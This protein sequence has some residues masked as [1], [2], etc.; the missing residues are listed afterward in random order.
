[1]NPAPILAT[2]QPTDE[3]DHLGVIEVTGPDAASFL[4]A[5]LTCDVSHLEDDQ[6]RAFGYCSPKGRLLASGLL[7]RDTAAHYLV[8]SA[9]L[10]GAFSKR[11]SMYVLRSKLVVRDTGR[12]YRLQGFKASANPTGEALPLSSDSRPFPLAAREKALWIGMPGPGPEPR[13]LLIQAR[14][15]PAPEVR[16]HLQAIA[17]DEWRWMDI[18][19]GLPWIALATQDLFVPQMVNLEVLGGVDFKKGCYPGQEVVARS[20]YL[21]KL[22]RRTLRFATEVI[23]PAAQAG[24]DVFD[25]REPGAQ[26][27]GSVVAAALAPAAGQELLCEILLNHAQGDLR[28]G[29]PSGLA[30]APRELPYRLPDNEVFVR[31]KL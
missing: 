14:D 2:A 4:H 26:A 5:Q 15:L 20:Q 16:P 11:L 19:S 1:M 24:Q 29:S 3:L 8:L 7:W 6:A 18:A 31:P 17:P 23:D 30:L 10:A 21:G 27:I 12:K 13:C 28:V 9:D 22:K 25:A